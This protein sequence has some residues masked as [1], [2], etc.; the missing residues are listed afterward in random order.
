MAIEESFGTHLVDVP[1][2]AESF[3]R[4]FRTR[5][6]WHIALELD[7]SQGIAVYFSITSQ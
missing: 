4:W 6:W 2:P 3:V 7:E 5:M 1:L